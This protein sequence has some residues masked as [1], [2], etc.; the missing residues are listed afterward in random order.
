MFIIRPISEF[1]KYLAANTGKNF[2]KSHGKNSYDFIHM[3]ALNKVFIECEQHMWRI[4]N[5]DLIKGI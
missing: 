5:R 3:Q 1:E 4:A 2:I